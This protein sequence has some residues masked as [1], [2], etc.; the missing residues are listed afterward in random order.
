MAAAAKPEQLYPSMIPPPRKKNQFDRF[1]SSLAHEPAKIDGGDSDHA[2]PP[3]W[4][5]YDAIKTANGEELFHGRVINTKYDKPADSA[6]NTMFDMLLGQQGDKV[7]PARRVRLNNKVITV[8]E[9]ERTFKP[10]YTKMSLAKLFFGE[11]AA[12]QYDDGTLSKTTAAY[13]FFFCANVQV[14]VEE[15]SA[16]FRSGLSEADATD[17]VHGDKLVGYGQILAEA[18]IL[19]NPTTQPILGLL[20]PVYINRVNGRDYMFHRATLKNEDHVSGAKSK[21]RWMRVWVS[22]GERT[23]RSKSKSR[24]DTVNRTGKIK[25]DK[26]PDR[27]PGVNFDSLANV[28]P[29]NIQNVTVPPGGMVVTS[30][31]EPFRALVNLGKAW[32]YKDDDP[33]L[34]VVTYTPEHGTSLGTGKKFVP[35]KRGK[36]AAYVTIKQTLRE[37]ASVVARPLYEIT[38]LN[39]IKFNW[40]TNDGLG[41]E[42]GGDA[43]PNPEGSRPIAYVNAHKKG[44][45]TVSRNMP[46]PEQCKEIGPIAAAMYHVAGIDLYRTFNHWYQGDAEAYLKMPFADIAMRRRQKPGYCTTHG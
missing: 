39:N 38:D 21:L 13:K 17:A 12:A 22:L 32:V 40:R 34:G 8:A 23:S 14:N 3:P 18:F 6:D 16:E 44:T 9:E 45:I 10:M 20:T 5:T 29:A 28:V 25:E 4:S 11:R 46:T 2:Q 27:L 26:G 1:F 35:P 19:Y 24:Y 43:D 30:C 42:P 15:R 7:L 41:W 36:D 33:S 37:M 31:V